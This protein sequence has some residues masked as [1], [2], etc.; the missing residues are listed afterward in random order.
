LAIGQD[1]RRIAEIVAYYL[2]VRPAAGLAATLGA[3]ELDP[4]A[5]MS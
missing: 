1:H 2:A 4:A 5:A 3:H